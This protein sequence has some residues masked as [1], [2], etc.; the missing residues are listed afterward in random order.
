LL[1]SEQRIHSDADH[2]SVRRT[3]GGKIT[4]KIK[5]GLMRFLRIAISR[6]DDASC[7]WS[8][9]NDDRCCQLLHVRRLIYYTET[10]QRPEKN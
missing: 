7:S 4:E 1:I 8:I 3:I 10:A 9:E 2:V 6:R 5:A